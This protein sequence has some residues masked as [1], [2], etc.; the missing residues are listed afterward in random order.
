MIGNGADHLLSSRENEIER[1]LERYLNRWT[2][3]EKERRRQEC[4]VKAKER[5]TRSSYQ[6]C[7]LMS[8]RYLIIAIMKSGALCEERLLIIFMFILV[9]VH[10]RKAQNGKRALKT[11]VMGLLAVVIAVLDATV[12]GG[13]V[14]L[15]AR[16]V[17]AVHL[18]VLPSVGDHLV[19]VRANEGALEAMKVGALVALRAAHLHDIAIIVTA[20]DIAS[21]LIEVVSH[22]RIEALVA[23]GVLHEA[24]FIAERVAARLAHAVKVGLMFSIAATGVTTVL[25]ETISRITTGHRLVARG[26]RTGAQL[27][28]LAVIAAVSLVHAV[29]LSGLRF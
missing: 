29:A 27:V 14:F 8:G 19:G 28:A 2:D 25:I 9:G 6:W 23:C 7:I 12:L 18:L 11:V 13:R 1:K 5:G 15:E 10:L 4:V 17:D 16:R 24:R 22:Q 20:V 21:K 3:R 26:P